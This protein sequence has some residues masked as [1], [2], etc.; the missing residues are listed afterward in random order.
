M[1]V[2]PDHEI[3]RF[4]SE[5]LDPFRPEHV[6]PASVD[7]LLDHDMQ[8]FLPNRS[9]IDLGDPCTLVGITAP[10]ATLSDGG[11]VLRPGKSVLGSTQERV[12]LPP[13][14][15]ARVEGKSS[16]GRIFLAVHITAGFI[17]PGFQGQV[18]LEIKNFEEVP[19]IL[20]PGLPFCQISFSYMNAPVDRPYAGRYQNQRGVTPSRYGQ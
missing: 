17:D 5:L 4:G 9:L 16:L 15:M 2:L 3:I 6:Q 19:I 1:T 8:V 7:L 10:A 13:D 20:R 14:I 18:T 11:F 12:T